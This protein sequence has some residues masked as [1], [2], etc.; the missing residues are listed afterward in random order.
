MLEGSVRKVFLVRI[1]GQLVDTSTGAHL[2]A[3][4]FDGA[5]ENVF[6]LQDTVAESVVGSLAA[7]E[8]ARDRSGQAQAY[9]ESRRLCPVLTRIGASLITLSAA[10]PAKEA[11]RFFY[12][13]IELDPDLRR[14]LWPCRLLLRVCRG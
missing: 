6:A 13:A 9:W 12:S 1:T 5:L 3:K 8:K 7:L 2:W 10:K 14:R 11:L 4:K